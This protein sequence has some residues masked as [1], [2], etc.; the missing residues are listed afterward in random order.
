LKRYEPETYPLF[1][2]LEDCEIV[3]SKDHGYSYELR[4]SRWGFAVT[5]RD[6]P[7]ENY[8]ENNEIW[9]IFAIYVLE[10]D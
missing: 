3:Y 4:S 2:A 10:I 5:R 6:Q 9:R 1:G 8:I 7:V